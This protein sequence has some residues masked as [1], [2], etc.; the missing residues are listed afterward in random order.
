MLRN[1]PR[2]CKSNIADPFAGVLELLDDF[3]SANADSDTITAMSISMS[4]LIILA[5]IKI[6]LEFERKYINSVSKKTLQNRLKIYQKSIMVCNPSI[7]KRYLDIVE[8]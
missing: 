5:F 1:P 6:N 3:E 4:V 2:L 8:V 7:F